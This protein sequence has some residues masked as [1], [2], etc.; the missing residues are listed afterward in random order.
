MGEADG[1]EGRRGA[2]G[3]N[4]T[5]DGVNGVNGVNGASGAG[6][7]SI[8]DVGRAAGVS[9]STVSHVLNRTRYVSP[10]LRTRVEAVRRRPGLP[11]QR[12]GPRAA[13]AA[14]GD[15]RA[16]HPRRQQPLLPAAGPG[17][18]GCRG[19]RGVC[20]LRLQQRPPPGGGGAAAG[21][22]GAAPGGRGDPG[23]R[24]AVAGGAGGASGA[25]S[26]LLVLVGSRIDAAQVP[27]ADVVQ[28]APEGGRAAVAHLLQ[29]GHRR[30]GLIAGPPPGAARRAT[31]R[32]SPGAT[33]PPWRTRG[34]RPIRP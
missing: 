34:S 22:P 1:G 11:P 12:A 20:G 17:G 23:R 25:T 8:K 14:H 21:G 18:A 31:G 2:R 4:G 13:H 10:A 33:S 30:I 15:G 27:G 29:R 6:E 16:D 28:M 7:A 3:V 32:P 9:I 24:R 19:R 26:S 5:T